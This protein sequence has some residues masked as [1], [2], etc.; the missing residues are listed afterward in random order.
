MNLLIPADEIL[1]RESQLIKPIAAFKNSFIVAIRT[2]IIL[3]TIAGGMPAYATI[4][5]K[6]IEID[7][8]TAPITISGRVVD[9]TG[10]PLPSVTIRIK[11]TQIAAQT[12]KDGVFSIKANEGDILQ[13][14]FVGYKTVEKTVRGKADLTIKMEPTQTGLNEIVVVGY[15]V[16]TK[17]TNVGALST[18]STKNLLQNP[19]TNLT[20]AL[21]GRLPGLITQQ[22]SGEPG[23]D[24]A[25]LLIR[26]ITTLSS[27]AA[28]PLVLVDGVERPFGQIDFNEV[29]SISILKDASATAVYGVRGA[30]GVVLVTTRRGVAGAPKI[31][32]SSNFGV[33]TPARLPSFVGS[34]DYAVLRNEAVLNDNPNAVVPYNQQ[35]LDGYKNHTDPYLYPDVDYY[36]VF[37]KKFTPQSNINLNVSGGGK[38][39]RYFVSGSYTNQNGIYNFT[40]GDFFDASANYKRFNF[41]SNVD[42]DATK[43]TL[44]SI[45]MNAIGAVNN[46]PYGA[47]GG[48][49]TGYGGTGD[50]FSGLSR[51]APNEM[52]LLNPDGTYGASSR[53]AKVQRNILGDLQERGVT[54]QYDNTVEISLVANQKLD[55]ILKGLTAKVNMS[56]NSYYTQYYNTFRGNSGDIASA[57]RRY[58]VDGTDASGNYIYT[59]RTG[60][61]NPLISTSSAY[62]DGSNRNFYLEGSLFWNGKTGKSDLSALV[63][64][65]QSR[66]TNNTATS[67]QLIDFPFSRMG[68]VGRVTY[69]YAGKY[70]AE[71]NA[72]YNG[73]ENF[74][75]GH[76]FGLFPSFSAGWLISEEDFIKKRLPAIT[77]LKLRASIGQVGN[78]AISGRRFL[79][80]NNSYASGT[81]YSYGLSQGSAVGGLAEGAIPTNNVTWERE[82]SENL[83]LEMNLWGKKLGLVAD[84]FYKKRSNI[85]TTPTSTPL[86]AGIT[87]PVENIGVVENKGFELEANTMHTIGKVTVWLRGN[88]AFA[89]NKILAQDEPTPKYPWLARTGQSVGQSF[90]Y[91]TNGF[92]NSQA[93]VDNRTVQTYFSGRL[94][95]GDFKYKDIDGDGFITAYDQVPVGK[96]TFPEITYGFSTGFSYKG[97]DVSVLFAGAGNTSM[98]VT[99][100]AAWEFFNGGKVLSYQLN[101][102]TPAT[103][104]TATYPRLS[105]DP[106]STDN[107]Y[108]NSDF[109]IRD[110]SYIRLKNAEIGYTFAPNFVKKIGLKNLR[111]YVNG[112]NLFTYSKGITYLDPENRQSRGWYYPQSTVY[113]VGMSVTF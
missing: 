78:D 100:E 62:G 105:S 66:K 101:R 61:Y 23:R 8:K 96:P 25:S 27:A 80:Y 35:Q 102:W 29:E 75:A 108:V 57:Y 84:V 33:Q 31:S 68:V 73:S 42:I 54:E 112:Q 95:P 48:S 34:Y 64:Y 94:Q 1:C 81:G 46:S 109:W 2:M 47:S 72:G 79:Y 40:Q 98:F 110:A 65:N 107:N 18:V 71:L 104:A 13:F 53:P 26:G 3:L 43:T 59:Q 103:A 17:A 76:R 7:Y 24:N 28:S 4:H 49:A 74:P 91:L 10:Q 15:G 44:I 11:G 22:T 36:K 14:A 67:D 70:F 30:N 21:Q 83:G 51:T 88:F 58:S 56:F 50:I 113:N 12:N 55:A 5:A 63:L 39:A 60:T 85:L 41:R 16:K 38:L 87:L 37:L 45:N 52:N 86:V 6:R 106:Q 82:T 111:C 97:L 90:G 69:G 77:Y 20:N 19:V 93:E 99:D 89:R 9:E 32:L 92:Y